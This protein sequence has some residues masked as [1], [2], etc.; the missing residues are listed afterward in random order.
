MSV[1]TVSEQNILAFI[2][3]LSEADAVPFNNMELLGVPLLG[4]LDIVRGWEEIEIDDVPTLMYCLE[5]YTSAKNAEANTP[6]KYVDDPM[7]NSEVFSGRFRAASLHRRTTGNGDLSTIVQV[8]RRGYITSLVTASVLDWSEARLEN[9]KDLPAGT[10]ATNPGGT[11]TENYV[12]VKWP[13]V[14]PDHVRTIVASINA[15][16]PAS[17]N[18]TIRSQS[19]GTG[20]HRIYTTHE[21]EDDG[22]A[23]IILLLASPEYRL[24]GFRSWFGGDQEEITYLWN[25]PKELA[26]AVIDAGKGVGK[27]IIPSYSSQSGLVDLVIYSRELLGRSLLGVLTES[28]CDSY[29]MSS[30]YMGTYYPALYVIPQS[31]DP[32]FSYRKRIGDNAD[33]A[34][35]EE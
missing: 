29:T 25:V 18:P 2:E 24:T 6:L 27:S 5:L 12:L 1:P 10:N 19:Y 4:D 8:L 9:G 16:A 31:T 11:T 13:N 3:Q 28:N 17:F 34:Q 7:I 22:S 32:G 20:F 15:L 30:F 33:T 26:Q 23:T 14:S 35:D 21:I